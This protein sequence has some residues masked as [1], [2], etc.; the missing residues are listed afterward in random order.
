M[1]SV[2]ESQMRESSQLT[3]NIVYT[4]GTVRY[5]QLFV[6][7][8]LKWL[9]C[10]FRLV[11]NGC[12]AEEARLLRELC[13]SIS[14][15]EF[16]ALPVTKHISHGKALNYLQDLEHSDT[17][18]FM[19]SDIMATGTFLSESVPL[20]D[21]CAGVFSGS[22]VFC[23]DDERV[24]TDGFPKVIGLF[25]RTEEGLCLGGTYLAMYDNKVLTRVRQSLSVG[26]ERYDWADVPSQCQSWLAEAGFKKTWYDTGKLLNLMLHSQGERLE[27]IESPS[28]QHIT[29]MSWFALR[30]IK[31]RRKLSARRSVAWRIRRGLRRLMV[32]MD[33][34]APEVQNG[35]T[36]DAEVMMRESGRQAKRHAASRY[37]SELL[38]YLSE[39]RPLPAVPDLNDP[40]IEEK[41]ELVAAD[42]AALYE[43]VRDQML[44]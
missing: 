5:L 37:F 6:F 36:V 12:P 3:F 27:F 7:S 17:F 18:C 31:E 2:G 29:G 22:P 10:S 19:D 14:R 33:R 15:L 39:N 25:N 38:T 20:L 42:I 43:E 28:L 41:I 44:S 40:E 32:A 13:R 9:D 21:R 34:K 11:A 26:F 30:E 1:T 4:P 35:V 24:M 23:R 16:L 8:L